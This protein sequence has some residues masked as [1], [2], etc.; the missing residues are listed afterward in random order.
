MGV[1][2]EVSEPLLSSAINQ[3]TGSGKR[4]YNPVLPIENIIDNPKRKYLKTL[5]IDNRKLYIK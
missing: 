1:L 2:G 5:I 3:I 4:D